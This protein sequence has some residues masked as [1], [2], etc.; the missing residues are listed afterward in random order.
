MDEEPVSKTG[1]GNTVG[2]SMP[3]VSAMEAV[4]MAEEPVL[5]TGAGKTVRGSNPLAS[6]KPLQCFS[7]ES[8]F[9][10]HIF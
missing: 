6:A 4:R 9:F 7:F 5:K 8:A 10:Q 2:G 1:A 3:L